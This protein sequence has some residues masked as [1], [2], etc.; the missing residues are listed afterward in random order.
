MKIGL[1]N[2]VSEAH[3]ERYIS[4]TLQGFLADIEEKLGEKFENVSLEGFNRNEYFLLIF[5][6]SGGVEGKFKQIFKQVKGPYLL[7]SSGLHNSFAASLE[8]ASFLKQ[9]GEK[10]EIIHGNSNY[11]ARRIKE[12]RKIFKTKNRLVSTK[13]GAIGKP[14]DWLIASEV[15]YNKIKDVLGI[16][17]IDIEMDELVKEI[18]Q[19]HNFTHSKLNDITNKGFDSKSIDGAL[20]IYSGLKT[21]VNK[22]K[23]DG[24]TVRCF[25]LLEIYKNTG[26]LGLS[27]LNDEGITAG[28]EGDIPALISMVILHYLTNEPVFMANPSSIDIDKNEIILAHCTLPLNMPDEFY[29][30]THFES[31]LGVGIKGVIEEGEATIF[32]LSRD[33]KEYFVSGGEIIENLNSENLCRTQIRFRMNEEVKYFLQSP[34][35]NHHL[36]CKGDYNKLVREFFKWQ[37]NNK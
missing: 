2:L 28:C 13:L 33:G 36:I 24:I 19:D 26:C 14:S 1:Y 11:I 32:K 3:N 6:K 8:I 20:K 16:S 35:G 30:K 25:D 21:I 37:N 29:L 23:L 9:N 12:L 15:D 10:V 34:L 5:I 22:Y 27:L 7:L 31:G 18:E 4:I 17:L